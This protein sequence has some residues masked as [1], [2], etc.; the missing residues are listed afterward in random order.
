MDQRLFAP[1][2]RGGMSL[3]ANSA[4]DPLPTPVL[5]PRIPLPSEV[6]KLYLIH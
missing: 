2:S 3:L 5:G 6:P 4:A 1:P